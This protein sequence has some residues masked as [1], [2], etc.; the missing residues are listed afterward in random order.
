[1]L[2]KTIRIKVVDGRGRTVHRLSKSSFFDARMVHQSTESWGAESKPDSRKEL[3][4]AEAGEDLPG[5]VGRMALPP[6]GDYLP[7]PGGLPLRKDKVAAV[8]E[9][10]A[11]ALGLVDEAGVVL[12][13]NF[14][15]AT[16]S[17]AELR[18]Y[19]H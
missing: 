5:H 8:L 18:K 4:R 16:L 3:A 9:R 13:T 11:L 15:A 12:V 17:V 10:V 2:E 7:L 6:E 1:M 14:N 19:A